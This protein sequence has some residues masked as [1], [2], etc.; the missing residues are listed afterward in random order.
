MQFK[1]TPFF[2]FTQDSQSCPAF[3]LLVFIGKQEDGQEERETLFCCLTKNVH[4]SQSPAFA[5]HNSKIF[6]A[7]KKCM[8]TT[9]KYRKENGILV[10]FF[11]VNVIRF[12]TSY[13]ITIQIYADWPKKERPLI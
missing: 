5:P 11:K 4:H 1:L 13:Q 9:R 3:S 2:N 8:T 6:Q 12:G 10:F 7:C